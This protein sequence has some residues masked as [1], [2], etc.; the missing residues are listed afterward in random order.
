MFEIY[1]LQQLVGPSECS[2]LPEAA[3]H[4]HI[5]QPTLTRSV[6]KLEELLGVELFH[7]E[8]TVSTSTKT[9]D[10]PLNTPNVSLPMSGK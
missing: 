10:L 9:A 8:K 6:L 5:T 4:L 7:R 2:T 1:L 3:E